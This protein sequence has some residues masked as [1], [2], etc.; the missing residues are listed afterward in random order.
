MAD[1]FASGADLVEFLQTAVGLHQ[2]GDLQEAE[3]HYRSLLHQVPDNPDVLHFLGVLLHQLGRGNE[4]VEMIR[5]S[6]DIYP[7]HPDVHSNLGNILK[8]QSRL[9]DAE[10]CYR[11][12]IDLSPNHVNS[13]YNLAIVFEEQDKLVESIAEYRAVIDLHPD[14]NEARYRLGILLYKSGQ[15]DQAVT[16]FRE[17]LETEP[18]NP[19]ALHMLAAWTG[20]DQPI[21]ATN[22]YVRET[23]DQFA[24]TFEKH[25]GNLDY[26]A[27]QL[28]I[29]V[30]QQFIRKPER[31]LNVLDAG[32]GTGL[33]GPLLRPY[34]GCLTGVDISSGMIEIAR[35]RGIY[36]DL[37]T[38]ELTGYLKES[39]SKFDLVVATDTLCYFGDL[40]E[41][42]NAMAAALHTGGFAAFTVEHATKTQNEAGFKL[43]KHGRF[44]HTEDYTQRVS[45]EAGLNVQA[46]AKAILRIEK[47]E[48]VHGLVVLASKSDS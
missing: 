16:S 27:P 39:V 35:D 36:D 15:L 3:R 24:E 28:L 23:F 45:K 37:I 46:M 41:V 4:A 34:S 5:A 13:H 12:A 19:I 30:I 6:I 17:W 29:D 2:V 44:S 47:N 25:L 40:K 14:H 32:C 21:R 42:L 33:C 48:P 9:T 1:N 7:S 43:N 31:M 18:D 11:K 26:Q 38:A 10:E 8:E 20:E 22:D